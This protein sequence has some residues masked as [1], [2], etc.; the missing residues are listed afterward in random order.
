M[1]PHD[2]REVDGAFVPHAWSSRVD[3]RLLFPVSLIV[4][5]AAVD[6]TSRFV[7]ASPHTAPLYERIPDLH[8]GIQRIPRAHEFGKPRTSS[9]PLSATSRR[10]RVRARG[11]NSYREELATR[12]AKRLCSAQMSWSRAGPV[13]IMAISTPTWSARN[14]R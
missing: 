14:F 1:I 9:S 8:A 3:T 5:D 4:L 12:L 10:S 6:C 11:E 13:E 2:L 7:A